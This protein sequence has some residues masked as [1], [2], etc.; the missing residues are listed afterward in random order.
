MGASSPMC[1]LLVVRCS[2]IFCALRHSGGF[3]R[4][5]PLAVQRNVSALCK[6]RAS[7]QAHTQPATQQDECPTWVSSGALQPLAVCHVSLH[8]ARS[9]A[10]DLRSFPP[11]GAAACGGGTQEALAPQIA[12]SP[13]P[14]WTTRRPEG[15]PARRAP[16]PGQSHSPWASSWSRGGGG[17]IIGPDVTQPPAICQNFGGGGEGGGGG[18]ICSSAGGRGGARPTTTTRIPLGC[19]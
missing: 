7:P 5:G 18:G 10:Q 12:R 9:L 13:R 16:Q 2:D 11:L 1:D 4:L 14:T 6:I 17:T 19:V 15:P 8:K 3:S